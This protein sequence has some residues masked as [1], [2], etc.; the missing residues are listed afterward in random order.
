MR[1]LRCLT[2]VYRF[3]TWGREMR[4]LLASGFIAAA[5]LG[6]APSY[7]QIDVGSGLVGAGAGAAIGAIAGGGHGAA[8][9]AIV[10]GT[11]G[12]VTGAFSPRPTYAYPYP[13]PYHYVAHRG[14]HW[15]PGHHNSWGEWRPG[16]CAR[17]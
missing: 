9:G 15:I 16:H 2:A 6:A 7:A 12:A 17:Y 11:V 5:L 4:P 14:C 13:Y 1:A 8:T 10:G 3:S